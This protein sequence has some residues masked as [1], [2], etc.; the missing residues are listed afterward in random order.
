[1]DIGAS[2]ST[3]Y[4]RALDEWERLV[5]TATRFLVERASLGKLTSYSELTD[6]L[7]R[8]TGLR[9][10]DF[11]RDDER[12][13][14]GYLLRQVV[15]RH[16]PSTGLL[17]SSLVIYLNENDAGPGFYAMAQEFGRLPAN[18]SSSTKLEFWVEAVKQVHRYYGAV[19]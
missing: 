13:A 6:A 11:D 12:A 7:E 8:R 3:Y 10:F 19:A 2:G 18:A 1:M 16:R 17:I 5:N 14:L 4:G 9:R 15:D